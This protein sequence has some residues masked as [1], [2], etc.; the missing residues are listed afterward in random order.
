MG[1]TYHTENTN[2]TRGTPSRTEWDTFPPNLPHFSAFFQPKITFEHAPRTRNKTDGCTIG[3]AV[4][5]G[6]CWRAQRWQPSGS[7]IA[8]PSPSAVRPKTAPEPPQAPFNSSGGPKTPPATEFNTSNRG[9]GARGRG[10]CVRK[11]VELL[12][13]L[14]PLECVPAADQWYPPV[15][16]HL[17]FENHFA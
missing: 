1:H 2:Y 8:T 13:V 6:L 9:T 7:W 12:F 16:D 4:W 10:K 15:L 17:F 14:V 11:W 5:G 3:S